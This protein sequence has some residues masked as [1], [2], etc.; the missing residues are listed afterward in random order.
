MVGALCL[1]CHL[2]ELS[3]I[4][5]VKQ[6]QRAQQYLNTAPLK[7]GLLLVEC[8]LPISRFFITLSLSPFKTLFSP[9]HKARISADIEWYSLVWYLL[10]HKFKKEETEVYPSLLH[11]QLWQLQLSLYHWLVGW[12]G[13]VSISRDGNGNSAA[14]TATFQSKTL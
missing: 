4:A 8:Q 2:N 6:W 12:R 5:F 9:K 13:L 11:A 3:I 7:Q 1:W 14:L 10:I